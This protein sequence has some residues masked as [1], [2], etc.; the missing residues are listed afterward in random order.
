MFGQI[1]RKREKS[2]EVDLNRV[3]TPMLDMTFQILFFLIMNFRLASA[4]GQVNLVIPDPADESQGSGA[5]PTEADEYHVRLLASRE[6]SQ[7]GLLAGITWKP[8]RVDAEKIVAIDPPESE[9]DDYARG[10]DRI[11][12]GLF[13][14]LK[15]IQPGPGGVKPLIRIEV[16]SGLK[17]SELLR[18]MDV[19][20]KLKLDDLG[21]Q[22]TRE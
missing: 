4:E 8:K 19:A 11:L 16:D 13:L 22:P 15:E 5:F 21:V 9:P 10:L 3:V 1:N 14:K 17:Y 2:A 20:R 18:V 6:P 12:Y 7:K